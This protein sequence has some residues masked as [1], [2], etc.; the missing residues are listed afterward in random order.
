MGRLPP[1]LRVLVQRNSA[2]GSK[3]QLAKAVCNGS[4]SDL[5]FSYGIV[6]PNDPLAKVPSVVRGQKLIFLGFD[7]Q[8]SGYKLYDPN[9]RRYIFSRNAWIYED[10]TFR[11]NNLRQYDAQREFLKRKAEPDVQTLDLFDEEAQA[12]RNL[13]SPA[14]EL[15]ESDRDPQLPPWGL[16][17]RPELFGVEEDVDAGAGASKKQ[18]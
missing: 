6:I 14:H 9:E 4:T 1:V 13:F 18:S 15:S 2:K 10:F 16:P 12:Y 17:Q 3:R 5:D 7:D 8:H 11:N